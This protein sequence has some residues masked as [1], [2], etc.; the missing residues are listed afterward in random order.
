MLTFTLAVRQLSPHS[1]TFAGVKH[2]ITNP[3]S[4]QTSRRP[5]RHCA[6]IFSY[7]SPS[8]SFESALKVVEMYSLRASSSRAPE[9][10]CRPQSAV[11]GAQ[12]PELED[13]A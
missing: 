6:S 4:S 5:S 12:L 11:A 3:S 13:S 2:V 10:A 8:S 9:L 7:S 1:I